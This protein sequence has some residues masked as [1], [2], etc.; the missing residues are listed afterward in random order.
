MTATLKHQKYLRRQ[1][2]SQMKRKSARVSDIL[3]RGPKMTVFIYYQG[4]GV[5]PGVL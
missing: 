1:I 4:T 3:I 5:N 2:Q